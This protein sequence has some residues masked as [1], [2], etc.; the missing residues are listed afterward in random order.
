[1]DCDSDENWTMIGI[2]LGA[3]VQPSDAAR[4]WAA[5]PASARL[6]GLKK[7]DDVAIDDFEGWDQLSATDI[8]LSMQ[9]LDP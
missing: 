1:L 6:R 4:C 7:P 3:T 8:L 9:N 2:Q 5:S